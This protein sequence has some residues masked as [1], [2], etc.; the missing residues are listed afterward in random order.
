M[1]TPAER[2]NGLRWRLRAMR[3]LWS[4]GARPEMPF[5]APQPLGG[6]GPVAI[7]KIDTPGPNAEVEGET[8]VI[9]G[10]VAFASGPTGQVELW[11]DERSLGRARLGSPRPDVADV[12]DAP[13]AGVSGFELVVGIDSTAGSEHEGR[14][15]IRAVA[16]GAR[17]ERFELEPVSI[18]F[19][20]TP[21][22]DDD[23]HPWQPVVPASRGR[24]RRLRAMV[25]THQLNLG[26]AQLYLMDLLK[27]LLRRGDVEAT[28]VGSLDGRLRADLEA[29]GVPVHLTSI[30]PI[31]DA[32]SHRGRVEELAAWAEPHDFDVAL[33]NTATTLAFPGAEVAARLGIPAL[34]AIHESFPPAVIWAELGPEVRAMAEATL[35]NAAFAIFEAEATQ[36]LY[37][38]VVAEP[39]C[40]TIPY[41]LDLEPI[42]RDRARFD[43]GA[44]RRDADIPASAPVLLCVGTVEPRKAQIPLAQAF[45]MIAAAHPD[46]HLV[47]VGGRE[48]EPHSVA[49][50]EFI[51]SSSARERIHLI[52]IT[53]NVQPWYGLADVLVCASDVESLPRTVLEAMAWET[54]VLATDV[55]GLPELIEHGENGWLCPPRDIS[56][57]AA[58]L[59]E[60]LS[61]PSETRDSIAAKARAL[62][63]RRHSLPKY[64]EEISRLLE[65]A[66]SS[67]SN[68][69][70][71]RITPA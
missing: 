24:E 5:L 48:E 12:S 69:A 29:M 62:V 18:S 33:I 65:Q 53:P 14:S 35:S 20:E 19:A 52:P 2:L 28:V 37:E 31:V 67:P 8:L 46:A 11:L 26:G 70:Q 36:R 54:P 64:A 49:L 21:P 22:P 61:T 60:V 71:R 7:G 42:D 40:R 30:F 50:E 68:E 1:T 66:V 23:A 34:W 44:A 16:T 57:L 39:R 15:E 58:A 51:D 27:G 55:F 3:R 9:F 63:E 41:G 13:A 45:E 59:D 17:G 38:H 47:F 32:A 10:W 56:Q 43:A 6:E 4:A 25:V